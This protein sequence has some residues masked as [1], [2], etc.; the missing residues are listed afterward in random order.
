MQMGSG[1]VDGISR[2]CTWD[3]QVMQSG[4]EGH[5]DGISRSC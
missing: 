5:A 4:Y 2:S 3:K 1:H